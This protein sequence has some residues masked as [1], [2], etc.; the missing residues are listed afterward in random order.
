MKHT[1]CLR[2]HT[3]AA[4]LALAFCASAQASDAESMEG[5]I[6]IAEHHLQGAD[7]TQA[8]LDES[9]GLELLG[10]FGEQPACQGYGAHGTAAFAVHS[11]ET[12]WRVFFRKKVVVDG[13][14]CETF[15]VVEVFSNGQAAPPQASVLLKDF[16]VCLP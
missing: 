2:L 5:V 4:G 8:C 3:L 7:Q 16:E 14:Q 9:L 15:Q 12:L 6:Q 13:D 1:N 10:F 11:S